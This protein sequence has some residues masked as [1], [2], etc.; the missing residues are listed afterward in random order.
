[1]KDLNINIILI[2]FVDINLSFQIENQNPEM[3]C[4]NLFSVFQLHLI[5]KLG[6]SFSI[7]EKTSL[8]NY[9]I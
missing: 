2:S 5:F 3:K 7:I 6:N 8:D 9:E 4:L 1:M